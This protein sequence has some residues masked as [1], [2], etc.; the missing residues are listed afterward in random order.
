MAPCTAII[1]TGATLTAV[2]E[3]VL[4]QLSVFPHDFVD[5]QSS[6][7]AYQRVPLYR[8][9]VRIVGVG[10][11]DLEVLPTKRPDA[12]IGWDVLGNFDVS[13]R[14]DRPR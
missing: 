14:L 10:D 8:V 3:S 13:L 11:Y 7:G 5:V 2:P 4:E 9:R 1:D 6:L 12:A